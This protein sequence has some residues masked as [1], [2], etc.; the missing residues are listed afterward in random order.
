[1]MLLWLLEILS[2]EVGRYRLV[3]GG[4]LDGTV[5][6]LLHHSAAVCVCRCVCLF[7]FLTALV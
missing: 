6:T 5:A 7:A 1:M 4:V 3:W 2:D